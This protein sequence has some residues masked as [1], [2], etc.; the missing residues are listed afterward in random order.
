MEPCL[1]VAMENAVTFLSWN[2]ARPLLLGIQGSVDGGFQTVVESCPEI[3]FPYPLLTSIN[4][5]FTSAL[6]LLT[7]FTSF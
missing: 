1:D 4:P 7:L 3:H 6:A 5:L 2:L